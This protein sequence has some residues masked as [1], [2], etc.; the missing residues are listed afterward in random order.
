MSRSLRLADREIAT[1]LPAFVMG[2]VN[3]TPDSFWPSSRTQSTAAGAESAFALVEAGADIIDIGGESTRPGSDYVSE[4]EELSRVIP[5][6]REIRRISSVPISIDTRKSAV[7]RA[8]LDEGADICN[9]ISALADDPALADVAASAGIPVILMHKAGIPA[10]MQDAPAY[11]DVVAEVRAFL[12]ERAAFAVSKGIAQDRIILDPGIGFGKRQ[13]D[14]IALI[15]EVSIL[16]STGFPV[17]MALSRKSCI[18]YMT[19]RE[20]AD[21][22]AGTLTA[23]LV[24]VLGG[25]SILRVHDVAETLDML[26]V[27]KET[28]PDGIS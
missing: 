24:S 12:C 21:R 2:I 7:M 23:N 28:L 19:G 13:S 27:L 4:A 16:A 15:R 6:V 25:A 26:A 11:Q 1:E 5:L 3:A 20:V 8:A 17:L 9:D 14:N 22:L 10:H 18:G